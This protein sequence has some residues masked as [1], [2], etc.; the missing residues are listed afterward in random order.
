MQRTTRDSRRSRRPG[1][2]S[3]MKFY[4]RSTISGVP[5]APKTA[6][7]TKTDMR[8]PTAGVGSGEGRKNRAD[9]P[10]GIARDPKHL[11][12][13]DL[14]VI[15][16]T[17]TSRSRT[18]TESPTTKNGQKVT[19]ATVANHTDPDQDR[20]VGTTAHLHI[21]DQEGLHHLRRRL[22]DTTPG[23]QDTGLKAPAAHS[24]SGSK[25]ALSRCESEL[26]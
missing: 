17:R 20:V 16:M 5:V 11:R 15:Q 26:T 14:T 13:A 25:T 10:V 1:K 2:F 24:K 12:M 19:A 4:G 23:V 7:G 9:D 22:R 3:G 18:A 8:V 21:M 6:I